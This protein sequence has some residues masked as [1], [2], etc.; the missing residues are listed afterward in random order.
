MVGIWLVG[1]AM[2]QESYRV[3]LKRDVRDRFGLR[4]P[5]VHFNEHRNYLAMREHPYAAGGWSTTRCDAQIPGP[6]HIRLVTTSVPLAC[7]RGPRTA[8]G[9]SWPRAGCAE[10]I[11]VRWQRDEHRGGSERGADGSRAGPTSPRR[12]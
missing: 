11:R 2:P 5:N 10:P 9:T 4:V 3:T 8:S 7:A 1:E 6:R 12:C